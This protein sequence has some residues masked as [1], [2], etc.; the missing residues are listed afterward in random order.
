MVLFSAI[1]RISGVDEKI[2]KVERKLEE[3]D[4][5]GK[6]NETLDMLENLG[7][8]IEKVERKIEK[9]EWELVKIKNAIDSGSNWTR[10]K[11]ENLGK[12][13]DRRFD[14]VGR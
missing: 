4:C 3:I 8:K 5:T 10:N 12:K 2:E 14:E 13:I 7:E 9:V 11:L 6:S 1:N